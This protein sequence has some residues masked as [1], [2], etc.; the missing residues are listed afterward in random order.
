MSS[1]WVG[2]NVKYTV[3]VGDLATLVINILNSDGTVKDISDTT[4]YNT[5]HWKVWKP[6]GT[7]IINGSCS[8]GNR[9]LGQ[10][11]YKLQ[12]ADTVIA[13]VGTWDGEVEIYDNTGAISDQTETFTFV[14]DDSY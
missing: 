8:F 13:N 5:A 12:S 7:L 6:D 10:I 14:I 1:S 4:S 2:R 11:T 3:K 9:T